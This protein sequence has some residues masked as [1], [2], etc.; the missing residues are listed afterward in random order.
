MG[1]ADLARPQP[2]APVTDLPLRQPAA[3]RAHA[4]SRLATSGPATQSREPTRSAMV[5]A[6]P[7]DHPVLELR[8]ESLPTVESLLPAES[9]PPAETG[10]EA[11]VAEPDVQ[12]DRAAGLV[13]TAPLLGARHDASPTAGSPV[14]HAV[15]M[16]TTAPAPGGRA[17]LDTVRTPAEFPMTMPTVQPTTAGHSDTAAPA[18]PVPASPA[19][20]SWRTR[21]GGIGA[22]L[23][24]MRVRSAPP[25]QVPVQRS[26]SGPIVTPASDPSTVDPST[27]PAPSVS[28]PLVAP[29]VGSVPIGSLDVSGHAVH[30]EPTGYPEASAAPLSAMRSAASPQAD[31]ALVPPGSTIPPRLVLPALGGSCRQPAAEAVPRRALVGDMPLRPFGSPVAGRFQMAAPVGSQPTGGSSAPPA[32]A[33]QR[34]SSI[35]PTAGNGSGVPLDSWAPAESGPVATL[36]SAGPAASTAR[37]DATSWST[38]PSNS[39]TSLTS[40]S[41]AWPT[42][43]QA[44]LATV[45]RL[46]LSAAAQDAPAPAPIPKPV[47]VVSRE[48][49]RSAAVESANPVATVARQA[50]EATPAAATPSGGSVATAAPDLDDLARK[51]YDRLRGRL[52]AELRLDR[53][54]IG[55]ITDLRR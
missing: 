37:P 33:L 11:A 36:M 35:A 34:S 46:G 22:P 55:A 53:E 7:V 19:P 47:A 16:A 27:I 2:Y 17:A 1:T 32:I 50:E 52:A 20:A 24:E 10:V 38:P 39:V 5:S 9:V 8:T 28:M 44:S 3:T 6:P 49:D 30:A 18:A 15:P 54:R 13:G 51:L 40:P 43:A 25:A 12:R 21:P 26:T 14:D 45:S 48:P 41:L 4:V 42:Q 31:A 23:R 29:T